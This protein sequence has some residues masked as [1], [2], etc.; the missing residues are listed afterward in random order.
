M[1][2]DAPAVHASAGKSECHGEECSSQGTTPCVVPAMPPELTECVRA[3][4]C[5]IHDIFNRYS[6]SQIGV[7]FNGGK[8][9]VVM[10]ELLRRAVTAPVLAQCCIF[11]VE[12]ND[13][14]E[15]LRKFRTWYMQEVAQGIPLV[16]QVLAQDMRLS[17]WELA[18]EHPLKVVFMGTRKTDPHGRYQKEAIEK[19]TPG[20]PDFLRAC[21]LFHWSVNDVWVYTRLLCIPQCSLY[22]CGYTSMGRS[23]NTSR[24]PRLKRDD[25]SYRPAWELTCDSAEREGRQ[26]E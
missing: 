10:F 20:W 9:S 15:E 12:Y 6:P 25:G 26:T 13:E 8:D 4:E 5:L 3:S 17:L 24:N 19:T 1:L 23:A 21:P 14:F 2:Q 16:H 11:V 7:A 18:E 22:E